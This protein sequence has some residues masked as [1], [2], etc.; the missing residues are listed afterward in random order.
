MVAMEMGNTYRT[1]SQ[2]IPRSV[3]SFAAASVAVWLVPLPW[4]QGEQQLRGAVE[5]AFRAGRYGEMLTE[6]SAHQRD[7]FPP[8]W[9][10]PPRIVHA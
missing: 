10:P 8:H 6:I 2:A 9:A 7:D 1:D 4:T 5:R 3:W